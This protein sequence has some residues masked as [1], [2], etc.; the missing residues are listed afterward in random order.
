MY[1][2]P[3][4]NYTDFRVRMFAEYYGQKHSHN[5]SDVY[6]LRSLCLTGDKEEIIWISFLY[7]TCYSVATTALL[8]YFFPNIKSATPQRLEQ[9]WSEYKP[10]LIFQS[11]R[12]WVKNLN[13]FI[14]IVESYKQKVQNSS[15]YDIVVSL[16]N[17]SQTHLYKW[18]TS[19]YYCGRFSAMLFMEAVYGLLGL[20]LTQEAYLSWNDCKTCAQGIL[21]IY[22]LDELAGDI[23]K[24]KGTKD[25]T[26][27]QQQ[28]LEQAL[29]EI[30][31]YTENY[32]G[33]KT[34]FARVVG[35]LCSYFKLYKQTRYLEYYTDRRLEELI[36]YEKAFPQHAALWKRLYDIR[37]TNVPH[38]ILG[39]LNGWQG[40]R[41]EKC[42]Q[43][44]QQGVIYE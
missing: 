35:Y 32:L 36:H 25:L 42:K 12:R 10:K 18:F 39:E 40:V 31:C 17:Q 16:I 22:Y 29:R 1:Q 21:V 8:F 44:V 14:P 37:F 4:D 20:T 33:Y 43:F 3:N 6:N 38:H 5:D 26:K 23:D 7:S 13:K 30:I 9:F 15:Q 19:I 27:E 11:D 2:I 24:F 28:W 34:N 41:K